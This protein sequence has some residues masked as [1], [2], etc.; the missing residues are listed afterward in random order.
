MVAQCC[1]SDVLKKEGTCEQTVGKFCNMRD[2]GKRLLTWN[3][4][5][6]QQKYTWNLT[7]PGQQLTSSGLS[8][9]SWKCSESCA[10]RPF[11][12]SK[13][14]ASKP[15]TAT[16]GSLNPFITSSL[17][18]CEHKKEIPALPEHKIK[19][20]YL[21]FPPMLK[22]SFLSCEKRNKKLSIRKSGRRSFRISTEYPFFQGICVLLLCNDPKL[23]RWIIN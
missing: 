13:V 22:W 9:L 1:V 14:S 4:E 15:L 20:S 11:L 5:K 2:A 19:V 8:A 18:S 16:I 17:S 10:G 23:Y 12:V 21:L 7:G 3:L 6:K